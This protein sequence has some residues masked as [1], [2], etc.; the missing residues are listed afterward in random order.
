[1]RTTI[2]NG[3]VLMHERVVKTLAPGAVVADAQKMAERVKA[4]LPR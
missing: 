4:A 2:V 3:R 1:M